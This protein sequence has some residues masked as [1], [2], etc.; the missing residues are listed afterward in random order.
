MASLNKLLI[1]GGIISDLDHKTT[2]SGDQFSK[3]QIEVDRPERLENAP[4]IKDEFSVIAWRFVSEK[5]QKL[6]K[7]DIVLVEGKLITRTYDD[8]TGKRFWITEVEARDIRKLSSQEGGGVENSIVNSFEDI[9]N[10]TNF[11]S[12]DGETRESQQPIVS[13]TSLEENTGVELPEF[14]FEEELSIQKKDDAKEND[15][16]IVAEPKEFSKDIDE[17]VP[18]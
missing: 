10:S 4:I 13:E 9:Q 11:N 8:D 12:T 3:F 2:T 18:F 6:S 15:K 7:G 14:N 16:E 17:S 1:I 5:C